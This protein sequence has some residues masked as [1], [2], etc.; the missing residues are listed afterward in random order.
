M[1]EIARRSLLQLVVGAGATPISLSTAFAASPVPM[2]GPV[3]KAGFVSE[4]AP[5]SVGPSEPD[6]SV[7][8]IARD[9]VILSV[10]GR[11]SVV[12]AG[13]ALAG[14][15]MIFPIRLTEVRASLSQASLGG[16]VR[17]D[18]L[19]GGVSILANGPLRIPVGT[20]SSKI[21]GQASPA[22]AVASLADDQEITVTVVAAGVMAKGLQVSLIGINSAS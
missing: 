22:L 10:F 17:V 2:A 20:T 9:G 21:A 5:V 12:C 15:R 19:A 1:F 16:D 4:A 13:E 7:E 8:P 3:S 11:S 18:L 14:T 6:A